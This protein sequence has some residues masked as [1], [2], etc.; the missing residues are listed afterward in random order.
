MGRSAIT[1]WRCALGIAKIR[2]EFG[3]PSEPDPDQSTYV[4]ADM[5][6]RAIADRERFFRS[7]RSGKDGCWEWQLSKNQFGYGQF[8]VGSRFDNSARHVGAH[9]WAYEQFVCKVGPGLQIDHLCRNRACVNPSHLELVTPQENTDRGL[10]AKRAECKYGHPMSGDNLYIQPNN[11]R[12]ACKICKRLAVNKWYRTGGDEY[13]R[14]RNKRRR[15]LV[16]GMMS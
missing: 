14:K 5:A 12:R 8:V 16:S 3:M 6:K 2:A 10:K 15:K 4:E 11:G 9:R 7:F 13:Y 1:D